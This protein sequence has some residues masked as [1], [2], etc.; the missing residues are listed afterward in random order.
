KAI[1]KEELR[2]TQEKLAEIADCDI[3]TVQ[4]YESG[5]SRIP[6]E[7]IRI[8]ERCRVEDLERRARAAGADKIDYSNFRLPAGQE[9]VEL[10]PV[11]KLLGAL[12]RQFIAV[13]KEMLPSAGES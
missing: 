4:R 5:E 13:P 10:V 1:R 7:F 12:Y 11:R 6:P 8:V 3:K 2:L 9:L